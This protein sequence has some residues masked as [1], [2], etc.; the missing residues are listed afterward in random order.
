VR[1]EIVTSIREDKYAGYKRGH[2]KKNQTK[3]VAVVD[4][5]RTPGA[6]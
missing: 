4:I 2:A 6:P 1:E 3:E 5:D